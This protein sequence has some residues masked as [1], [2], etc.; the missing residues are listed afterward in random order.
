MLDDSPVNIRRRKHNHILD[1]LIKLFDGTVAFVVDEKN[2]G[3]LVPNARIFEVGLD[4]FVV[5]YISD[6]KPLSSRQFSVLFDIV[7]G[8]LQLYA[9][10]WKIRVLIAI[11]LVTKVALLDERAHTAF[12]LNVA[13]ILHRRIIRRYAE[14]KHL[15]KRMTDEL[16]GIPQQLIW[17]A[18][19]ERSALVGRKLPYRHDSSPLSKTR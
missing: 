12:E 1:F 5:M 6:G 13:I 2:K 11:R 14:H 8:S 10:I 3:S 17:I 7:A 19:V 18:E 9:G 15:S 16:L 4:A